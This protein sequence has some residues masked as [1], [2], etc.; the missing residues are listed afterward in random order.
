MK[1]FRLAL[2][3]FV[4]L[5][6]AIAAAQS[7]GTVS[8]PTGNGVI[9]PSSL[10]AA[11]N[12]ALTPKA[13]YTGL[14][15]ETARAEAAETAAQ[16]KANLALTANALPF[17]A[18]ESQFAEPNATGTGLLVRYLFNEGTGTTLDDVSGNGNNAGFASASSPPTWNANGLGFNGTNTPITLPPAITGVHTIEWVASNAIGAIPTQGVASSPPYPSMI[19]YASGNGV[20]VQTSQTYSGTSVG[21]GYVNKWMQFHQKNASGA[22]DLLATIDNA[23]HVYAMTLDSTNKVISI[24]KDGVLLGPSI[25]PPAV[26]AVATSGIIWQIG[27]SDGACATVSNCYFNGT[28][29]G[30]SAST[31]LETQAQIVQD[32]HAWQSWLAH[33]G[34]VASNAYGPTGIDALTYTFS[35][36]LGAGHNLPNPGA[37]NFTAVATGFLQAAYPNLVWAG[38]AD[39][40]DNSLGTEMDN[41][42][43]QVLSAVGQGVGYK[44]AVLHTHGNT[45][46]TALGQNTTGVIF[47]PPPI[48]QTLPGQ[49]IQDIMAFSGCTAQASQNGRWQ[50]IVATVEGSNNNAA[51]NLLKDQSN[52]IIRQIGGNIVDAVWDPANDPR[53]G[54]DGA[55]AQAGDATGC[56]PPGGS[57]GPVHQSDGIHP[58]VCGATILGNQLAAVEAHLMQRNDPEYATVAAT[59][60]MT[61]PDLDS[62]LNTPGGGTFT[63]I[64]C[65]GLTA[66]RVTTLTN[67]G[68]SP[69]TVAASHE[70][71][72]GIQDLINGAATFSLAAGATK[73]FR[74]EFPT[75]SDAI[76]GPCGFIAQ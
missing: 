72:G 4:G 70:Y 73:T 34:V 26:A 13:D 6:P 58:T 68:S 52:P 65:G 31:T 76:G 49:T 33:E 38:I 50:T 19:G 12:A 41:S 39:G 29:E 37:Q 20:N 10:S 1:T 45:A 15:A 14:T 7:A 42:C 43:P 30:Y 40:A 28:H 75:G 57:A 21:Q 59:Y 11:I 44:F 27:G 8:L 62:Y 9:T 25:T 35:E 3:A 61:L 36:S 23:P 71:D 74:T 47:W 69:E 60:P 48:N 46:S 32:T 66:V 64:P 22:T 53:F 56:T 18:I 5:I 54:V 2:A 63:L 24:Y 67:T 55:G 17:A 51:N 16:T